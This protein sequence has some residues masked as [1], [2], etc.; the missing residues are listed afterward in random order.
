M[1]EWRCKQ[2]AQHLIEWL[3]EFVLRH[4]EREGLGAD[5]AVKL[6][7]RAARTVYATEK[8]ETRGELGE[9]LLHIVLRQVF[10]TIPAISKFFYKDTANDTIKGFDAVH[11]VATGGDLELW[12]GEAKFYDDIARAIRDSVDELKEHTKR[13]YLRAEFAA[14]VNKIDDSWPHADTLKKLLDENT[15]LDEVFSRA[16]IPVLLTYDSQTIAT[17]DAVTAEFIA[18]FCAEVLRHRD[19]FASKALPK[20]LRVHLF[21]LPLGSK[22]SLVREFDERLKSWQ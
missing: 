14:I 10:K 20:H 3:P 9:L 2:L 12:L 8:V 18:A 11:V 21:L 19:T 6:I 5:N 22:A 7:V 13:D 4:S 16:C 17:H 15:S 1:G